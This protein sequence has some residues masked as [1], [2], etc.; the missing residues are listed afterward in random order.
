MCQQL[1]LDYILESKKPDICEMMTEW[2]TVTADFI[3]HID[4]VSV[5]IA[6]VAGRN[7]VHNIIV[8]LAFELVHS[9]V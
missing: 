9:A 7:A 8:I 1:A 2:L 6:S 3:W 4:A 5:E